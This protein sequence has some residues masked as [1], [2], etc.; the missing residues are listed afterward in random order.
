MI[1]SVC[2][3]SDCTR[4]PYDYCI[5]EDKENDGSQRMAYREQQKTYYERYRAEILKGQRERRQARLANGQCAV[6]NSKAT[7]GIYCAYHYEYKRSHNKQYKL[8]AK[9]RRAVNG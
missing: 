7:V 8:R 2:K 6:C 9:E 5:D 3:C 1:E 4:C